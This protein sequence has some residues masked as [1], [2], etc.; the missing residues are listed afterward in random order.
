MRNS[1]LN[2]ALPSLLLAFALAA[3]PCGFAYAKPSEDAVEETAEEKAPIDVTAE[4]N[5]ASMDSTAAV[6]VVISSAD[7]LL[8]FAKDARLDSWSR[9]K[10]IVL[11]ADIDLSDVA[12]NGIPTF[13]GTFDGQG[14]TITGLDLKGEKSADSYTGLFSRIQES[15]IVK[16]LT[17][18]GTIDPTGSP[19]IVGGIVGENAGVLLNCSFEGVVT[20]NDYVGGIAGKN[21][22]NGII[23]GCSASGYVRATHFTGGIVGENLGNISHCTNEAMVNITNVD[24]DI[25]FES[26]DNL[27]RIRNFLDAKG[28]SSDDEANA[29]DTVSDSGGIAGLSTGVILNCVNNGN[30]GYEH[31]GYN[32][33][34]IAGRQSGYISECTNNGTVRGRKD[35]GGITGQAE[36]YIKVDLSSD[37]AYQLET[38]I[39]ELS[40]SISNMLNDTR[41]QSDII[42]SRLSIIQG[43]T[44]NA[45]EDA[46]YLGNKTVDF[47]NDVSSSA[48]ATYSRVEYILD[49]S[50]S[51]ARSIVNEASSAGNNLRS[52]MNSLN[53]AVSDLDAEQYMTEEDKKTYN[54]AKETL[55]RITGEHDDWYEEAYPVFYN[56]FVRSNYGT[57]T[58]TGSNDLRYIDGSGKV[59]TAADYAAWGNPIAIFPAQ[60]LASVDTTGKWSHSDDKL[61][62]DT[63]NNDDINLDSTAS[64]SAMGNANT[65]ASSKYREKYN[66]SYAEDVAAATA[67]LTATLSKYLNDM[68]DASRKDASAAITSAR[69]ATDNISSMGSTFDSATKNWNDSNINYPTLDGEYKNHTNSLADNLAGMNDNFG[70]LNDEMNNATDVIVD[71]LLVI[72]DQFNHIMH[73]YSDALDGVLEMDYSSVFDDKSLE[74]AETS[75]DATIVGCSNYAPVYGDLN[76]AGIAGTMAIEYDYDQESD[77]TGISD[78]RLNS[79]Y[80]TKCILRDSTNFGNITGEK[81]Y[82]GGITGLQEMGTVIRGANYADVTSDSGEYVGGIGGSSLSYIISSYSRGI[83]TGK[84]YVGGIAGDATNLSDCFS[85]VKINDANRWYGAIAGHADDEGD[86]K[87]NRFVSDDLAGIDR[88]SYASKAEPVSYDS[89]FDGTNAASANAEEENDGDTTALTKQSGIPS[90]FRNLTISFI[91]EDDELEDGSTLIKKEKIPYGESITEKD[92]PTVAQKDD[93]YVSW[94]IT[95][96]DPVITDMNVTATYKKYRTTLSADDLDDKHQSELLVDGLFKEN[97]KL[98]VVRSGYE[99][100]ENVREEF[101]LIIKNRSI[102]FSH[103]DNY[104]TLDVTV[105]G[106]GQKKRQIRFHP[107]TKLLNFSG[108]SYKLYQVLTDGS[109]KELTSTGTMGNYDLYEISGNHFILR[110]SIIGGGKVILRYGAILFAIIAVF[111]LLI[112]LAIHTAKKHGRKLPD[113]RRRLHAQVRDRIESKE[114]IFFDE[115]AAKQEDE[116]KEPPAE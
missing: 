50:I 14:H 23:Y 110:L 9:D 5:N 47:V 29:M 103:F 87:N 37:I 92:Y 54:E 22:I 61:F 67:R 105:P 57:A 28:N 88:I 10:R 15:G 99:E 68:T 77:I 17:V 60:T 70:I 66:S 96:I 3:E 52:S 98:E 111:V 93:Y 11:S 62:P 97:D 71:D 1:Y 13:G 58:Y 46:R 59:Y 116:E 35:V 48:D 114:Q 32:V 7:D 112:V 27:S 49:R 26:L 100:D 24:S 42:S 43:Y 104:E 81:S 63:S 6:D 78:S 108:T 85:L 106:D 86:I 65:Y 51:A 55:T 4:V 83:L 75:T 38:A 18:G 94:D 91:L 89:I 56:D 95:E 53:A 76:T 31:V 40:D 16:N 84:S 39:D 20:G 107:T 73:L 101:G 80:I 12:F 25:S 45:I 44:S 34:G 72:N 19:I 64:A 8:A 2:K 90:D 69:A 74:E 102:S 79:S 30:V 82:V 33:G 115:K 41:N 36:P 113:L 21:T 109:V